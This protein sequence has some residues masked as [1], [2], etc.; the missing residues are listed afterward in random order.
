[1]I[2]KINILSKCPSRF[3]YIRSGYVRSGS[4]GITFGK[5][6][7]DNRTQLWIV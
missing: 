3:L 4:K 6:L 1:M 7:K 2:K 5:L